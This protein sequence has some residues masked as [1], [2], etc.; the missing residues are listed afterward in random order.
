MLI[1]VRHAA[2]QLGKAREVT[3]AVRLDLIERVD[4]VAQG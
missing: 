2:E 1:G 4:D 3:S